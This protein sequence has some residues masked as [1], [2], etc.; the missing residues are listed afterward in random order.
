MKARIKAWSGIAAVILLLAFLILLKGGNDES[1]DWNYSNILNISK[2]HYTRPDFYYPKDRYERYWNKD[3]KKYGRFGYGAY[4][5]EVSYNV[6]NFR[7]GQYLNVYTFVHSSYEVYTYQGM[8]LSF[9]P[10]D[11]ELFETY[12]EPSEILLYPAPERMSEPK[13]NW[14]YLVKMTVIAKKDI[15]EGRYV[16]NLEADIP[17]EDK[18]IEYSNFRDYVDGGIFKAEKFFNFVLYAY[19]KD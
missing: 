14:T 4:P 11:T 19:D 9:K 2:E 5:G 18:R 17:S 15:P 1:S 10:Q 8:R 3:F 7:H 6:Y 12:T 13:E 16:F